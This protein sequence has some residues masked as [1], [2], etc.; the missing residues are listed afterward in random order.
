MSEHEDE[1]KK[2]L[3]ENGTF[4]AEKGGRIAAAAVARF[5]SRLRWTERCGWILVLLCMAVFEFALI[6]F[7]LAFTT[8]EMIAYAVAMLLSLGIGIAVNMIS[9]ITSMLLK[10]L[11][12]IKR[13]QLAYLGCPLDRSASP[14]DGAELLAGRS[15]ALTRRETV[16][17][18]VVLVIVALTVAIGTFRRL[19]WVWPS[20]MSRFEGVPVTLDGPPG[21]PV[22]VH[23]YLRMESG[24]CKV[25]QVTPKH[26]QSEIFWMGKGFATIKLSGGDALRLDPQGNKGEYWVRFE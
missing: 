6:S 5:D 25:L 12:E 3:A 18:G 9:R 15:R 23:L 8:K 7:A 13:L 17:W 21:S 1:L 22:Y 2:A 16:A 10:V 19:P 4:D 26:E 20:D 14:A 11:M 24:S